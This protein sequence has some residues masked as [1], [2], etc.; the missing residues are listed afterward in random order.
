MRWFTN[1]ELHIS[2]NREKTSKAAALFFV[3]SIQK[4]ISR[5]QNVNIALSGGSTPKTMYKEIVEFFADAV[6]WQ[7][8]HFF[9]SDER[10]VSLSDPQSN[11]GMAIEHLLNP[12]RV[13]E[14]NRHI[15]PTDEANAAVDAARYEETMRRHFDIPFPDIPR[16]DLILLG[17]GEDGHTA[18]LFPG[19]AALTEPSKLIAENWVEKAKTWRITFTFPL[20]N[21]ADNL[22]FLVTGEGK[23]PVVAEILRQRNTEFP[24]AYVRPDRGKVH[25]F[26]DEAAAFLLDIKSD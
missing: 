14:K 25:W 1:T 12:L 17:L 8:V 13:D 6:E 26:L 19:S 15:V 20:I 5:R 9:W 18:S 24:A 10:Y 3:N 22:L 4:R 7:D 21:A 11:A 16:F 2:E 23:A